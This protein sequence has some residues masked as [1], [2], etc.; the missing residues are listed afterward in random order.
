MDVVLRE[1]EDMLLPHSKAVG[2]QSASRIWALMSKFV[3][4]DRFGK[5]LGVAECHPGH[6]VPWQ[7]RSKEYFGTGSKVSI[8]SQTDRPCISNFQILDEL[9]P[10]MKVVGKFLRTC[11]DREKTRATYSKTSSS[12]SSVD[13][14]DPSD[15]TLALSRRLIDVVKA[16]KVINI[17]AG[18]ETVALAMAISSEVCNINHL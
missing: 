11:A 7:M 3:M 13:G 17:E 9:H 14:Q 18:L 4:L 1:A 15:I 5:T 16:K 6:P 12:P 10:P 2:P 8:F